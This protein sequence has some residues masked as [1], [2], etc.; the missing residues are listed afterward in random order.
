LSDR[1]PGFAFDDPVSPPSTLPPTSAAS[2]TDTAVPL[3]T[4]PTQAPEAVG[5]GV[6]FSLGGIVVAVL[7]AI[8]FK[9]LDNLLHIN[10]MKMAFVLAMVPSAL[11]AYSA[12]WLYTKGSGG[13]LRKGIGPLVLVLV[14]GLAAA[15]VTALT[16]DG[17]AL[18][19]KIHPGDSAQQLSWVIS[20]VA[21][22][23]VWVER[24]VSLL[25]YVVAAAI[26]TFGAL[27][28]RIKGN[29]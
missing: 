14:V 7:A 24:E 21:D 9:E 6:A 25:L 11:M 1:A 10:S 8:V 12:V 15:V 20:Y 2:V 23:K 4:E 3:V 27:Y 22:P 17:F 26:G 18:A 5:K 28:G 16:T 19:T 29:R 13:V